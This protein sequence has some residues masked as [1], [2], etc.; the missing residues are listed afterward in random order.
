[1][2]TTTTPPRTRA[3][4]ALRLELRLHRETV[5][6]TVAFSVIALLAAGLLTDILIWVA[7]LWAALLWYRLG[8]ED[9]EQA[10]DLR[11][12]LGLS[13]A[14][15]LRG[16]AALV[17]LL[18][19]VLTVVTAVGTGIADAVGM[20]GATSLVVLGGTAE[21]PV[22]PVPLVLPIEALTI[23]LQL[24]VTG[25]IVGKECTT[26]RPSAWMWPLSLIS[27]GG[28]VLLTS[29]LAMAG[30]FL[31]LQLMHLT[32]LP[33]EQGIRLFGLAQIVLL[34]ILLVLA[35]QLLRRRVR[36]WAGALDAGGEVSRG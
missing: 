18:S 19:L 35:L 11:A 20:D 25:L 22:A 8:R 28:A 6:G 12:G 31:V 14:D 30:G 33:F 5:A 13:R 4:R 24:T 9:V 17:V 2:T 34:A 32:E 3:L 29:L 21:G 16:R 23:G 15:A 27:Y 36:V 1:M 7:P 10:A 26:R